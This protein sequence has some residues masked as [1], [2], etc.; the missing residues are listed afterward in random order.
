MKNV[1]Q[2][3]T[4]K[5][6]FSVNCI[7]LYFFGFS[8][9]FFLSHALHP[10][11]Y[12]TETDVTELRHK[13]STT[14]AKIARIIQETGN[15]LKKKSKYLLPPESHK[16]FAS[17]WN[18]HYGNNLCTFAMYCVLYP[19]DEKAMQLVFLRFYFLKVS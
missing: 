10:M 9:F 16:T 3:A 5:N 12:F 11:L 15:S 17:K 1:F 6:K 4:M 14:H 7:V 18:E 13:A 2:K 8:C 19:D